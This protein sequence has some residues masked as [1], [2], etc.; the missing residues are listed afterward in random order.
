[1]DGYREYSV[2]KQI[3]VALALVLGASILLPTIAEASC[4][5]SSRASSADC[6]YQRQ[7]DSAKRAYG[8]GK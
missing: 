8:N 4:G 5:A 1:M 3:T 2:L 7:S 6:S